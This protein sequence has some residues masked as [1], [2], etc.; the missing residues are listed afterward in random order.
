VTP[1]WSNWAD[2]DL[3]IRALPAGDYALEVQGRTGT[4]RQ[5]ASI[6]YRF[7]VQPRWYE[8]LWVLG[9]VVAALLAVGLVVAL[10]LVRQRTERF[11]EANRRLE[12][13]IAERTHELED[14]NRKLAELATEDALTG[15][16][17]RRALE[18]GLRREWYRCLDQRRPLSVLMIDVDHFKAYNDAHGHLEGDVQLKGIAQRLN[19]QHD[20]QRELLARYG[21]EEFALLL[22]GV[23]P[24]EAVRRA[25]QIRAA[26]AASDAG[27]TVSIGVAGFVPDVQVEPDSLLRRA[28]AA[29]YGAKRAGRNRVQSDAG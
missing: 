7:Q 15:V 25:E 2:R 21:G 20:P 5:P 19:Q 13:R 6:T 27:M 16:A 12:A 26:I 10:W 22:P 8:Q 24:A 14:V 17:N 29:L 28:D 18:N 9:L 4:G 23:H 3:F 11:L 1:G